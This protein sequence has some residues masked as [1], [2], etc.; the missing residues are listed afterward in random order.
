MVKSEKMSLIQPTPLQY[1]VNIFCC[2][3]KAFN[4]S[5]KTVNELAF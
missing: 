5:D 4:K 3:S 2:L 1:P